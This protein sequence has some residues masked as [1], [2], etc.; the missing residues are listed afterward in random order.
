MKVPRWGDL[1]PDQKW[2]YQFNHLVE[3]KETEGNLSMP[4]NYRIKY[5]DGRVVNIGK[6]L[7]NLK[8]A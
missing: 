3:Y 6:W 4:R 1:T 2:D 7:D 8:S 5:D